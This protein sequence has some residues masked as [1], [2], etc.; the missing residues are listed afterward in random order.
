MARQTRHIRVDPE[1]YD[2]VMGVQKTRGLSSA[3][4]TRIFARKLKR[5]WT[6]R[7]DDEFL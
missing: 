4:T 6:F 1:F 2:L 3:D 7:I 5:G